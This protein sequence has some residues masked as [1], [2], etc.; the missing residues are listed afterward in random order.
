[1]QV[2]LNPAVAS[3]PEHQHVF[4]GFGCY[5]H[6][7]R[8]SGTYF[9]NGGGRPC[10]AADKLPPRFESLLNCERDIFKNKSLG[11]WRCTRNPDA[12]PENDV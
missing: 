6:L 10:P 11:L 1:M 7:G 5:N 8:D 3:L 12:I 4:G 9:N 2:F